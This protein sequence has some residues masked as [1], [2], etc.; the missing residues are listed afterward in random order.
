MNSRLLLFL[1]AAVLIGAAAWFLLSG[2]PPS[3]PMIDDDPVR[4]PI[5][6]ADPTAATAN[7]TVPTEATAKPVKP[8]PIRRPEAKPVTATGSIL[9]IPVPP[10]GQP[11]PKDIVIEIEAIGPELP[12]K[13]LAQMLEGDQY[14]YESIL[15]GKYR[16]RI[17]GDVW[18]DS[19]AE[20]AVTADQESRVEVL[21]WRGGLVQYKTN[22][23]ASELPESV[24]VEV[25][26]GRKQPIRARFQSR[27]PGAESSPMVGLS[28]TLPPNGVV[29]GLKAGHYTLKGTTPRGESDEQ[30]FEIKEGETAA[31]SLRLRK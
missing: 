29:M 7:S 15:V 25:L 14:R 9:V 27:T 5:S 6:S 31:L 10:E 17:W 22:P 18:V 13:P 1:L 11:I 23:G 8:P 4:R 30:I 19:T 24:T 12:A 26:D 21:L 28:A 20:V 16:I 2:E 3:P